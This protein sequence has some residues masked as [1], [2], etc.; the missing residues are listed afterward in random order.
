[1]GKIEAESKRRAR[2]YEVQKIVLETVQAAGILAIGLVA[3]NVVGAMAKLGLI[4]N[5]RQHELVRRSID[6]LYAQGFLKH[7]RGAL[8]LTANGSRALRRIQVKIFDHQRLRRWDGKWRV[9]IFDVP[10]RKRALRDSIRATLR[11]NGFTR[12][13]N[14]VWVYPF[15]CEDWVNLWK[16]ELN[17]GRTL[18]YLIVDSIEGDDALKR[19]FDL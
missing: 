8:A 14:S 19:R 17:I 10:E 9:L 2:R 6:R 16:A 4:T 1:M 5:P 12:V 7:E 18:L 3:P 11:A 15:D 13:Q